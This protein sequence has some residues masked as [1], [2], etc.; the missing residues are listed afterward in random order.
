[1]GL[2]DSFKKYTHGHWDHSTEGPK[3][4]SE[5]KQQMSASLQGTSEGELHTDVQ[6][7]EKHM[8]VRK[9]ERFV[10]EQML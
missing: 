10:V 8:A 7:F 3:L 4:S 1:M 2:L 5:H 6:T 9:A